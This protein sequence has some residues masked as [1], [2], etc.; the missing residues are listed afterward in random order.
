MKWCRKILIGSAVIIAL[1]V[2][3]CELYILY[4]VVILL[5]LVVMFLIAIQGC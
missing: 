5:W 1:V 3:V 4:C 2:F